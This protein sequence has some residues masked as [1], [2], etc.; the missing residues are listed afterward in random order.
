MDGKWKMMSQ[1]GRK[2]LE[3]GDHATMG[4]IKSKLRVRHWKPKSG[5]DKTFHLACGRSYLSGSLRLR[6]KPFKTTELLWRELK[7]T[8]WRT[9]PRT[10]AAATA[11]ESFTPGWSRTRVQ[12]LAERSLNASFRSFQVWRTEYHAGTTGVHLGATAQHQAEPEVLC[13]KVWT[14]SL[15]NS[16]PDDPALV[17]NSLKTWRWTEEGEGR[18]DMQVTC[19][20]VGVGCGQSAGGAGVT[21]G[22]CRGEQR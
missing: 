12:Q 9:Q 16:S 19:L 17:W 5:V 1:S 8:G 15:L 14:M 3:N 18:P 2:K 6:T 11:A 21:S 4:K 20:A 22:G 7:V 13:L 10:H